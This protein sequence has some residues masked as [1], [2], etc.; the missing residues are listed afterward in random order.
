VVHRQTQAPVTV[1]LAPLKELLAATRVPL[2]L[3]RADDGRDT[4][5]WLAGFA[6][7]LL[8]AA[9]LS[10]HLVSVRTLGGAP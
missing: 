4:Y 6:F 3:V 1:S 5:L 9:G 10:L 8:A 2:P 7:A